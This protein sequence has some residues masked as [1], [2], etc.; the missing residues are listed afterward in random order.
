MLHLLLQ[1]HAASSPALDEMKMPAWVNESTICS[2]GLCEKP[3]M[4]YERIAPIQPGVQWMDAG[5]YCG[6]W[7]SQ[8]AFLNIGAWVSQQAVR[9]N[10]E[11]CG[12]H[13]EEILSCNIAEAWTNLKIDFEAF[14]YKSTP[15]PQTG[16]YFSWL[17]KQLA[18]GHVVAWMLMWN[19]QKY[20]IYN[21]KPPEGMYGHVEP[22]VGIQSNHPLNDTTVYDDD[23]VVHFTDGGTSTVHRVMSTLPC[24][25]AGEGKPARCGMHHYGLGNPWGFGWAAKGFDASDGRRETAMPASLRIQPWEREPDTRSGEKPTALQGTL[26]ATALTA[27]ASYDVYRWDSVKEAFT[28]SAA[29]KKASFTATS[30]THVYTDD[31]SFESDGT[32]YYR[33]VKAE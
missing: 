7:A 2:N 10:T 18:A 6:S 29:Y 8:R 24:K 33:V 17:K 9:N 20:P 16:A 11:N 28:Y 5:G 32:T 14:D 12:G 25:W 22:V 15:L 1:A 13:D 23:T 26:T 30:D 3:N 19:G 4:K 21:L 31:A 27:G